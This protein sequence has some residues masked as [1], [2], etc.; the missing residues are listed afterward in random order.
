M[1]PPI[2]S[3]ALNNID[4][5]Y[6]GSTVNSDPNAFKKIQR[7]SKLSANQNLLESSNINT[8]FTKLS[9]LYLGGVHLST[10]SSSY[11]TSR[12]HVHSSASS[13]LSSFST[14]TDLTSLSRYLDYAIS[15]ANSSFTSTAPVRAYNFFNCGNSEV[16]SSV[17]SPK[18]SLLNLVGAHSATPGSERNP[19]RPVLSLVPQDLANLARFAAVLPVSNLS[20]WFGTH[21]QLA[22][23]FMAEFMTTNGRS[24]FS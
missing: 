7:Y 19:G 23:R 11:Y 8:R 5:S 16:L 4:F 10:G 6:V 3:S 18:Q 13:F 22:G 17:A 21:P 20:T 12:Q 2:K 1:S 24:L 14:L 9:S 15:S